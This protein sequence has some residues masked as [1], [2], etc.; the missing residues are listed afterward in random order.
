MKKINFSRES[1]RRLR[2]KRITKRVRN[3][4]LATTKPVLVVTKTNQHI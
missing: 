1:Q 3:L 4:Q 2:S